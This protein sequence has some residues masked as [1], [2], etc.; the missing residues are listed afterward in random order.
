MNENNSKYDLLIKGGQVVDPANKINSVMDVAVQDGKIARVSPDIPADTA[1]KIA[2]AKGRYV[3]PGL[4]D[5][6]AH[7]YP[8]FP[9]VNMPASSVDV[10][11]N[12]LKAGVTTVC[13]AGTAG[14]RDFGYFK[15]HVVDLSKTR[16]LAYVNIFD[17]GML[18]ANYREEESVV[19]RLHPKATAAVALTYPDIVV[20]IKSA[21]YYGE[22]SG[23]CCDAHPAFGSVDRALEAG[24]ICGKPIMVD[25]QPNGSEQS[26]RGLLKRLG[27][28]DIHTH[29]FAQQFPTVDEKG[30]VYDHM[31]EARERGVM[32][33]LGH[34]AGSF[35]FRNG[36]PALRDGFPPDTLSTDL[37]RGSISAA[38]LSMLHTVGKY[39][40]MGMSFEECIMRST[41]EPAKL[42]KRPDLGTLSVGACADVAVIRKIEGEFNYTDCGK[43]KL[44]GTSILM[45]ELTVRAGEV[46]YDS[47][48]LTM[49]EWDKAPEEYW[50]PQYPYFNP[51]YV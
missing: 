17:G 1:K 8:L 10:D 48:G 28:G 47:Y 20:G 26:Y 30:K 15:E 51:V 35:W 23:P 25:F 16:V 19:E 2:D 27:K 42:I 38:V 46:V 7:I 14:W 40:N 37:H 50:Q 44:K 18:C 29:V 9:S 11:T 12:M 43:S 21:H 5:I 41:C 33:D 31:W 49:P 6:H 4:I 22:I 3:T 13:D 45:C 32:F 24:A 39:H 36:L 34:G